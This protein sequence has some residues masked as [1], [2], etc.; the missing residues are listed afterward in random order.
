MHERLGKTDGTTIVLK[1]SKD[2]KITVSSLLWT[3]PKVVLP[4]QVLELRW[5]DG[6]VHIILRDADASP[7]QALASDEKAVRLMAERALDGTAYGPL[8]L[9]DAAEATTFVRDLLDAAT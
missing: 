1:A 8:V 4:A 7:A 3:D 5:Q 2:G 9:E 6:Q